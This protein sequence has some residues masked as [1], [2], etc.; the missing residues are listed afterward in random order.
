MQNDLVIRDM[1]ERDCAV[2][3][4]AFEA[5]GWNKPVEQYRQYWREAE[6]GSRDV[7]AADCRGEF[8][9]YVTIVWESHYPPFRERKIPEVVDFNVLI[10]LR[11][12]GIG[13]ALMDAAE[14][15]IASRSDVAGI[16][17]GMT[18]DY[19]AAH[20]MYVRRGYVP[21]GRGLCSGGRELRYGQSVVVDDELAVYLTKW[22]G[23]QGGVG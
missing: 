21:D 7:L 16:G 4:S 22:V 13:T 8:A 18:V 1:A 3:S 15:R 20:I 19:A 12:G 10:K 6:S 23:L 5:Q 11:R 17:V 9:G 2:I 14:E